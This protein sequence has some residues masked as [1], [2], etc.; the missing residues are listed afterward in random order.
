[1]ALPVVDQFCKL[2]TYGFDIMET[3]KRHIAIQIS[4]CGAWVNGEDLHWCIALL[5]LNGHHTH[6][7]ILGS[8]AGDVGQRM[9][10]G[11]DL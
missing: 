8:L 7:G 9:P 10:I 4:G 2:L 5:E 3:R 6:H 11:T 1:M